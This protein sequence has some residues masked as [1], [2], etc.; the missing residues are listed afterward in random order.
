M[1]KVHSAIQSTH[2]TVWRCCMKIFATVFIL[3]GL[4]TG[5]S[6]AT[7]LD[8]LRSGNIKNLVQEII[9]IYEDHE[10]SWA[11]YIE[12]E[13]R[14]YETVFWYYSPSESKIVVGQFPTQ[15]QVANYWKVWSQALTDG[16]WNPDSFFKSA[17]DA[18]DMALFNQFVLAIHESAHAVTYRYDPEHRARHDYAINCREFYA[19]RITA[20]ILQHAALN[21]PELESMRKRYLE[22]VR[23]MHS[24]IP[25]QYLVAS[26][27]Y[28]NLVDDCAVIQIEQPTPDKLQAYASAYFTRWE[29]LL[30]S[31]LPTLEAAFETHFKERFRQRFNWVQQAKEWSNGQ[32]HTL[33][34]MDRLAGR[35][36]NAGHILD[37][38]KRAA[39]FAPDATL[40]FAE[41]RFNRETTELE[42]VY[43]AVEGE[44]SPQSFHLPWPRENAYITLRS[45]AVFSEH[46]FIATFE[47]NQNRSNL[48]QFEF[49][50]GKWTSRTLAE[51][52]N[53]SKA[54]VFRTVDN[55][56]FAALSHFYDEQSE[57]TDKSYWTFK[58]FDLVAGELIGSHDIRVESNTA[59]AV[60]DAGRFY[61]AY[62]R[63][64][65]RV[66]KK[67]DVKRIAGI[68]LEGTRDGAINQ[69]EF[70]WI[71]LLQ[72]FSDGSALLLTDIPG[73]SN[74]QMIRKLMPALQQ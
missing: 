53:T 33:R 28:P 60:D 37:G 15:G 27:D 56:V 67:Q 63:Q 39:A 57:K 4:Q 65:F 7:T 30:S 11:S 20:V 29:A 32:A 40:W 18:Y 70:G 6:M 38:A 5:P 66:D 8:A 62:E 9:S 45:I 47:E 26:A 58:E 34:E 10:I 17:S 61:L 71:Q 42:Y 24:T 46:S 23:S 74:R 73:G 36:L 16:N 1:M 51:W 72:F 14:S 50:E 12:W 54:F 55:R 2:K 52:E 49:S 69:A 59:M 21:Q 25:D 41:A 19:D 68:G 13:I 35:I 44:K 31:N 48:I 22:L 3:M 43:G 64:I